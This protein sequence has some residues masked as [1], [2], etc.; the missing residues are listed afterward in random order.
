MNVI[1][2]TSSRAKFEH[3]SFD[4]HTEQNKMKWFASLRALFLSFVD[5][6]EVRLI[7]FIS[8]VCLFVYIARMSVYGFVCPPAMF[9]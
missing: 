5:I 8:H 6:R 7:V 9:R 2:F 1:N 3:V 4:F